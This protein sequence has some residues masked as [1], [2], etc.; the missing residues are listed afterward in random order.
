MDIDNFSALDTFFGSVEKSV[1]SL[2]RVEATKLTEWACQI[3]HW[4]PDVPHCLSY[5]A[6]SSKIHPPGSFVLHVFAAQTPCIGALTRGGGVCSKQMCPVV[7]PS[8]SELNLSTV[9]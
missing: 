1:N 6:K 9:I 4:S 7:V 3:G 2:T 5:K 8:R